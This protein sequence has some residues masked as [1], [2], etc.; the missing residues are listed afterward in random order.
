MSTAG[1]QLG[2]VVIE[3]TNSEFETTSRRTFEVALPGDGEAKRVLLAGLVAQVH[4]EARL[5]AVDENQAAFSLRRWEIVARYMP[6]E[7]IR[8][9]AVLADQEQL[10]AA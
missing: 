2:L 4:P 6:R 3:A 1:D 10:F 8:A 9:I 5:E 7:P